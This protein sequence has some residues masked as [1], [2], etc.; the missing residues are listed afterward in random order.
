MSERI[1]GNYQSEIHF[2]KYVQLGP[3]AFVVHVFYEF[4]RAAAVELLSSL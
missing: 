1:S 3:E 4:I 2:R